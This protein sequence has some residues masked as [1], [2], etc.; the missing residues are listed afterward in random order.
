MLV[1]RVLGKHSKQLTIQKTLYDIQQIFCLLFINY[2]YTTVT[3]NL[4]VNLQS[5]FLADYGRY[6]NHPDGV[7]GEEVIHNLGLMQFL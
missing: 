7:E 5:Y 4:H 6:F 1:C 3:V 2:S